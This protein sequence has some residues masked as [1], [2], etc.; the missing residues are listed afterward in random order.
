MALRHKVRDKN[1]LQI[2]SR[3]NGGI[4]CKL[5]TSDP[6]GQSLMGGMHIHLR[7]LFSD[8]TVWLARMLREIIHLFLTISAIELSRASVQ[9]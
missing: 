5:D 7:I 3:L 6:L 4:P 1:L 8:G 2:S 9:L